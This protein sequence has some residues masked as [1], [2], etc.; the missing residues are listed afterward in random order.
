MNQKL[1]L[2]CGA[3]L[4]T[5]SFY[6]AADI[7]L[8]G[9]AR[10]AAGKTLSDDQNHMGYDNKLDF[11]NESL[12]ALQ[13][14][15][16]MGDGLSATAQFMARGEDD[17]AVEV[18]WA[19]LSY[20][21]TDSTRL[22]AGRL[23]IPFFRYSDYLDV[24]YAYTWLRP[25]AA[26]YDLP[27][28]SYDGV[29]LL[30]NTY[31]GDADIEVQAFTGA[32]KDTISVEGAP[33][34]TELADVYGAN[35]TF[36]MDWLYLRGVYLT[37]KATFNVGA[38]AFQGLISNLEAAGQAEAI[39]QVLINE[40][41]G[42]FAG[43]GVGLLFGNLNLQGEVTKVGVADS[44]IADRTRSYVSASYQFDLF[45]PYVL[46]QKIDDEANLDG[47]NSIPD[48]DQLAPLKAG[49]AGFLQEQENTEDG[50]YYSVGFRYGFHPSAS[51]KTDLTR[52]KGDDGEDDKVL[53]FAIDMVF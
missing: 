15:G 10:I 49:L 50:K 52:W 17:F 16:D 43:V 4:I 1:K 48:V 34:E 25:P 44:F 20:Q 11:R 45:T 21:L 37:S 51:F 39:D 40:D 12:F 27:Y 8:N 33:A 53:T 14:T 47:A 7:R 28:T 31:M 46:I 26:V 24:G 30:Y 2:L 23:R 3:C 9:F 18:E 41:T 19:Y 13:V 29:S 35:I 32:A 5:S 22:N 38:P 6:A 42:S 36:N